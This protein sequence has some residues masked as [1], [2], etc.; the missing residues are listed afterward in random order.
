MAKR[1]YQS[2]Q[3]LGIR[4]L[5]PRV[6]EFTIVPENGMEFGPGQYIKVKTEKGSADYTL[7]PSKLHEKGLCFSVDC[8]PK[9]TVGKSLHKMAEG[10]LVAV[11]GP[12]GKFTIN[13]EA[14]NIAIITHDIG[15]TPVLS[16]LESLVTK[17]YSGKVSLF[18]LFSPEF[19]TVYLD[20]IQKYTKKLDLKITK[21]TTNEMKKKSLSSGKI[22]KKE[23]KSH[24]I[25]DKSMKNAD[26][27]LIGRSQRVTN[28]KKSLLKA[29]ISSEQI[30]SEKF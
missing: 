4:T 21:L 26:F 9:S 8:H 1:Q 13:P 5:S 2:A 7:V 30:K 10:N 24:I 28:M 16:H 3:I 18:M 22:K 29:K 23:L 25:T 15:I 17:N 19:E 14:T 11:K 27:Y 6:K 12:Y 20:E